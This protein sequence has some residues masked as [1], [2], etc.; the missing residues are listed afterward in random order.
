MDRGDTPIWLG[1]RYCHQ[2]LIDLFFTENKGN[3]VRQCGRI[4]TFSY[5]KVMT[6]FWVK[7]QPSMWQVHLVLVFVQCL[8]AL[9]LKDV[10]VLVDFLRSVGQCEQPPQLC[11]EHSELTNYH[12]IQRICFQA[13]PNLLVFIISIKFSTLQTGA[14]KIFVSCCPI[15]S[16]DKS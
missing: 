6:N 3:G 5:I 13:L 7:V 15:F 8:A 11:K 16:A 12:S 1:Y 10:Q 4:S 9:P 2:I 14:Q